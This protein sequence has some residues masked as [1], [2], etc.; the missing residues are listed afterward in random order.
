MKTKELGR[1][2]DIALA[3]G[4][5]PLDVFPL[6]SRKAWNVRVG[7]FEFFRRIPTCQLLIT[8]DNLVCISGLTQIVVR[9]E[10]DCGQG[11]CDAAV[12]GQHDDAYSLVEAAK[13]AN[14]IKSAHAWK[15]EIH[16]RQ[17]GTEGFGELDRRGA[18]SHCLRPPSTTSQG[19]THPVSEYFIIVDHQHRWLVVDS[20]VHVRHVVT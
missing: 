3:V 20:G 15:P 10:S 18:V 13:R 6:D 14:N 19:E 12:T 1:L 2:R 4:E 9:S 7:W 8:G 5:D 11:G 16:N 17:V